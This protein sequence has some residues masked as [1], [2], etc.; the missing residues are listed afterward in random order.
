MIVKDTHDQPIY[1]LLFEPIYK[2]KVWGGR[3]LESLGRKLPVG[4]MIGE[5]WEIADL[6]S[7][8][9]S[10]GGGDAARSVITHGPRKGQTLHDVIQECGEQLLG[11]L[12]R[13]AANGFP[14][15]VKFLDANENLS[16]QVHPSPEYARSHPEAHL[17]SE[18]W[19]IVDA[20]PGSVIYKGMKEGT[21][22]EDFRKA[23][24]ANDEHAVLSMMATVPVKAGDCHYLPSGTC[25]ALGAGILVAEVQTPSD[26]TFRVYDWGRTDRQLHVEQAMAS[27]VFNPPNVAHHE[28][29]SHVAGMFTTVSR[30]VQCEH[31]IIEKVRMREGYE[32]EIPYDQPAVWMVLEGQGVITVDKG[33]QTPFQRGQTLLV[34]AHMDKARV[35]LEND[36]VWLEVTFPQA[37]NQQ[38]A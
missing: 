20:D 11:R 8:S 13:F 15:L 1:P 38:I 33:L 10:G 22:A 29:R 34:P 28:K 16:V 18:A 9:T 26:T 12:H 37:G 35:R 32:Q 27:I 36:T 4:K 17:K 30:L 21:N 5:S 25:H 31:F 3:R 2:E 14:L 24:A 6:A 23:I 19:Y 7:T